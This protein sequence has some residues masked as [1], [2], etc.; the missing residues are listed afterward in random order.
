MAKANSSG[1]PEGSAN[2]LSKVPVQP[3]DQNQIVISRLQ[4][5]LAAFKTAFGQFVF[6]HASKQFPN[7]IGLL[8]FYFCC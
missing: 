4:E 6:V 3:V 2:F 7:D 8:P 5:E 1:N